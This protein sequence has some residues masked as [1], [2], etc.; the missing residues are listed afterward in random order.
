ML[1]SVRNRQFQVAD[2]K[3]DS[4]WRRVAAGA[5]EPDT[6]AI[7]DRFL[8][9]RHCYIDIGTWIGPTLL[10]GSQIAATAFGLEPDPIAFAELAHNIELN[11]PLSDNIR[12]QQACI[13]P[14]TGAVDFGS[15]G[16]GGDSTSSLLFGAKK[17]HWTVDGFSFDD[18][19]ERQ[20]VGS[21]NFIKMDIEG[22]EYQVLPGMAAYLRANR[23][24]LLLSLHPCYL[25]LRP[26]GWP[27]RVVARIAAT[28]KIIRL[29]RFYR[30]IYDHRGCELSARRLL[31]LCRSKTTVDV[32]LTDLEWK[33]AA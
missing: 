33:R 32:V 17:T 24:T 11:R 10:Y 6:F 28:L 31:W 12:V 13:A 16:H 5:W 27:G 7:F 23:P 29:I 20:G 4:F 14:R 9:R 1:I 15:R 26:F 22:G 2:G 18:Y 30:Y 3:Y 8:D 21:C 25:K 19:I